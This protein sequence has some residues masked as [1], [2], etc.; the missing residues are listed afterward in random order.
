MVFALNV[1]DAL[2]AALVNATFEPMKVPLAPA[3]GAA[4]VTCVPST[5]EPAPSLTCTVSAVAKLVFTC[6]DCGVPAVAV[7]V[8]GCRMVIV[9]VGLVEPPPA[10]VGHR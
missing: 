9:Y 7:A 3:P 8:A 6:V 5:G 1:T 2:P 10:S 4:N